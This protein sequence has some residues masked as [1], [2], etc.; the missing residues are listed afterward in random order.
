MTI[1]DRQTAFE[2]QLE[3]TWDAA[4]GANPERHEMTGGFLSLRPPDAKTSVPALLLNTTRVETGDRVLVGHAAVTGIPSFFGD[5]PFDIPLSTA[6]SL[7]ARFPIVTPVGSVEAPSGKTRFADG[8]YFE[9]SGAATAQDALRDLVIG[10]MDKTGPVVDAEFHIIVI[11][12]VES[13]ITRPGSA[14]GEMMSPMRALLNTRGARGRDALASLQ[15]FA[16][17]NFESGVM[18]PMMYEF[19]DKNVRL[20]LGWQLS[21]TACDN[22]EHQ[23]KKS[24]NDPAISDNPQNTDAIMKLLAP[25][26]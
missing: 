3:R 11:R 7:S 15:Q 17:D 5:L 14:W 25:T 20:P 24:S 13:R 18:P 19:T 26:P 9:N 22:M 2:V 16:A 10:R 12:L 23:M 1:C 8:G 4:L 6:G 21:K